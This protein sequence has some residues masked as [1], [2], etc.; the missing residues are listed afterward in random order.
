M[1]RVNGY[2][3]NEESST[4]AS[5][6]ARAN[7]RFHKTPSY[8]RVDARSMVPLLSVKSVTTTDA[9]SPRFRVKRK[10]KM[11]GR[12]RVRA[13]IRDTKHFCTNLHRQLYDP[14]ASDLGPSGSFSRVHIMRSHF[15]LRLSVIVCVRITP[16][17]GVHERRRGVEQGEKKRRNFRPFSN[18]SSSSRKRKSSRFFADVLTLLCKTHNALIWK[19][20]LPIYFLYS[21]GIKEGAVG[22]AYIF[23]D[24]RMTSVIALVVTNDRN[25]WNTP[26]E[27]SVTG[28]T[29]RNFMR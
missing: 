15:I 18:A 11:L 4:D 16:P 21:I 14:C 24:W 8:K 22:R 26:K 12:G 5:I 25:I 7:P 9:K 2:R 3:S 27:F 17:A 29:S 6:F 23:Q 1:L 10:T 19:Q 13:C 20:T 28:L